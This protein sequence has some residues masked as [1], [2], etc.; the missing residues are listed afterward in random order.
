MSGVTSG[1]MKVPGHGVSISTTREILTSPIC[2]WFICFTCGSS[3][4]RRYTKM[5]AWRAT[6]ALSSQMLAA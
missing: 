4:C 5:H 2:H 1:K 6:P 3:R